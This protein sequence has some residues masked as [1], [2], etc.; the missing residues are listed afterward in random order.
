MAEENNTPAPS[1]SDFINQKENF[2]GMAG[3]SQPKVDI[4]QATNTVNPFSNRVSAIRQK[5]NIGQGGGSSP[6]VNLPRNTTMGDLSTQINMQTPVIDGIEKSP[7][8]TPQSAL[9]NY[10]DA[11]DTYGMNA[12]E[13][14]FASTKNIKANFRDSH[15]QNQFYDRY[16]NHEQFQNLGFNP[17]QDNESLYNDNTSTWQEIKRA[18]SQWMT[19]TGLGFADAAG[20][21]DLSDRD[22]AKK[23]EKAMAI[24]SSSIGGVGGFTSNLYLNSGYTVGIMAELAVEEAI[25]LAAEAGLVAAT[26]AT[27]G[28]TAP[29]LAANTATMAARAGRAFNKIGKAFKYSSKLGKAADTAYD[30][31]RTLTS[32]KDASKARKFFGKAAKGIGNVINPLEGTMDFARNINKMGDVNGIVKTAKGFGA[33][34]K[35][36]RNVRLAY[37]E[38]ALEGGMV[39]NEMS[40]D[41]YE[42]FV[43]ENGRQPNDDEAAKIRATASE[44]GR[45]TA[46]INAPVIMLSNKLT[47]DGLVRPRFS[48]I[49]SDFIEAG[50]GKKILFNPKA[51]AGQV[52]SKVPAMYNVPKI[53]MTY[54]RN[55][56]LIYR[57]LSTYGKANVAEGLQEIAQETIGGASKDYYKAKYAGNAMRGGYLAATAAN[58]GNQFSAQ[59]AET[60]LSGFLMGGFISPVSNTI[61]GLSPQNLQQEGTFLNNTVLKFTDKAAYAKSKAARDTSLNNTLESLNELYAD[62]NKYFSPDLENTI[63]QKEYVEGMNQS[64][65]NGDKKTY[66]DLK[67]AA[68]QKHILTALR[69]G[70]VDTFN[71]RMEELKQLSAEE[72]E[73]SYDMPKEQ[74]DKQLDNSLAQSKEIERRYNLGKEKYKN[75]FSPE[76]YK[77]GTV[78]RAQEQMRKNSWDSALEE[79]VFQQ[80]SFDN[81]LSRKQDLL[82][83]LKEVSGL[84]K[85]S[86]SDFTHIESLRS[87]ERES[88]TLKEEIE[89]YGNIKEISDPEIKKTLKY[90]KDKLASIEKYRNAVQ[91]NVYENTN[92]DESLTPEQNKEISDAFVGYA[93]VVAKESG[94]FTNIDKLREAAQNNTDAQFLGTRAEK[95]NQAVNA[96]LE[97]QEFLN[98]VERITELTTNLYKEKSIEI[99]KS[100]EAFLKLKDT[101]DMLGQ[102]ASDLEGKNMFIDPDALIELMK[103]GEVP[104]EIFYIADKGDMKAGTQVAY[105]SAD[106]GTAIEIFSNYAEHVHG[107]VIGQEERNPTM[108]KQHREKMDSD[109]RTYDDYAA[110]F[111]FDSKSASSD[112]PLSQVLTS[113]I[114]SEYATPAE[115]ELAKKLLENVDKNETVTFVNTAKTEGSYNPTTQ[116]VID[117]RYSSKDFGKDSQNGP[118]LETVILKQELSR[119][120]SESLEKDKPF[121]EEMGKLLVE[122]QEAFNALS[123]E[124]RSRLFGDATKIPLGLTNLEN[125]T[126]ASMNDSG[127]QAFLGMSPSTKAT[128]TSSKWQNFIKAVIEQINKILNVKSNGTILNAAM[129][130]ITAQID[131]KYSISG[132]KGKTAKKTVK[133][134]KTAKPGQMTVEKLM[135]IDNGALADLVYEDFIRINRNKVEDNNEPLLKDFDSMSKEEIMNSAQF[136]SFVQSPMWK[137]KQDIIKNYEVQSEE[138]T[139]EEVQETTEEEVDEENESKI[140]EYDV[141]DITNEEYNAFVNE[142]SKGVSTFSIYKLAEK[143]KSK[144]NLTQ[145]EASMLADT[146]NGSVM[147]R[148]ESLLG[149]MVKGYPKSISTSMKR[150]MKLLGYPKDVIKQ[151]NAATMQKY[152]WEGLTLQDRQAMEKAKNEITPEVK[153]EV[154]DFENNV[155]ELFN[156]VNNKKELEEVEDRISEEYNDLSFKAAKLVTLTQED[157]NARKKQKLQ[158][159]AFSIKINDI[160]VGEFLSLNNKSESIVE[161][162]AKDSDG[163]T[164]KYKA[165]KQSEFTI[166]NKEV[167]DKIKYRYSEA[168]EQAMKEE[169]QEISP[170]DVEQ[171]VVSQENA[172]SLDNSG[173]AVKEEIEAVKDKNQEE[174][175]DDFLN[176]IC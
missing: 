4:A 89:S 84:E 10:L 39:E 38:G 6:E 109:Q 27:F 61:A 154:N 34:Y 24:G 53:A 17:F 172:E 137:N 16:S 54:A 147:Q 156:S 50:L 35:D 2:V 142:G 174:T 60:F 128:D 144:A 91:K 122:A 71:T 98:Q 167:A 85:T 136:A 155:N 153:Q 100:L 19:L 158:E 162:I 116:S 77:S 25:M 121:Q 124:D 105:T 52:F 120:V 40:R 171:A 106:Y 90:K 65:K 97:P 87:M 88:S 14:I 20:F 123:M 132:T 141:N 163:I 58:L 170:E 101:N 49:G 140:T 63:E 112:V 68:G 138:T 11:V 118:A 47:F 30:L 1:G 115:I 102:L 33:F 169:K 133:R 160:S 9:D 164:V 42:D 148:V 145:Q 45:T 95:L 161:V 21:G 73:K 135:E 111:G 113:I 37:G 93:Q 104:K 51:A 152:I 125:F 31:G 75:P 7:I 44:A 110:Q 159:L 139:E 176:K 150:Q 173:A 41:L 69:M 22:V 134:G 151:M 82:N 55:P 92:E 86:A 26:A 119:R 36:I 175:D 59:G 96:L 99:K 149:E 23:Y 43:S 13:D 157:I 81:A 72:V 129:D 130:I 131:S 114:E 80:G 18:S 107:K 32:F 57:G 8:V 5:Y 3:A 46:K 28:G 62:P 79:M 165:G 76:K 70:R 143:V 74:F 108:L 126:L 168:L 103:T 12:Q 15:H 66:Y 166:S 94:D 83:N 29:I 67:N 78:E 56:K 64:Q 48:K 127:F 117:A 146:G